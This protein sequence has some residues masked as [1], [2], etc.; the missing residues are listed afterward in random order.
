M[1][2]AISFIIGILLLATIPLTYYAFHHHSAAK[3]LLNEKP[4]P[5][6]HRKKIKPVPLSPLVKDG[7]ALY[8]DKRVAAMGTDGYYMLDKIDQLTGAVPQGALDFLQKKYKDNPFKRLV[9]KN[10]PLTT[11]QIKRNPDGGPRF[12]TYYTISGANFPNVG[13]N[14]MLLKAM[15]C[16]KTGY[17]DV[18]FKIASKLR[19]GNGNYNDTHYLY[20]LLLLKGN[21]CYNQKTIE[22]EIKK[23]AEV[24]AKAED[25]AN[26]FSDLY[27][28]RI[29]F[30]YGA[31]LG[32][33][34]KWEWIENVKNSFSPQYGWTDPDNFHFNDHTTGLAL[35]SLLYYDAGKPYQPFYGN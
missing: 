35:L 30:L 32:D 31:G 33:Q 11:I 13:W 6:P 5:V 21:H 16:D 17:D 15:Y 10:D 18:D 3:Q 1:K 20:V 19:S 12:W 14:D 22:S 25:K 24:I 29:V 27:V 9:N 34:V 2:T 28:E 23:T 7:L 4:K 8:T 26:T